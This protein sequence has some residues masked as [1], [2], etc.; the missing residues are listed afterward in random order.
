M[1]KAIKEKPVIGRN[2]CV[3]I[4]KKLLKDD[5]YVPVRDIPIFY[6]IIK[7]YPNAKFWLNYD[8]GFK[9]NSLF[10][11]LGEDGKSKLNSDFA[12]FNLDLPT[13]VEYS[14]E[15]EKIGDDLIIAQNTKKTK[16]LADF[17]N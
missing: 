1:K 9:L 10:W 8:L 15:S 2:D 14:L 5:L 3:T 11:L 7:Q 17:L 13:E 4:I 6:K 16:S 12:V